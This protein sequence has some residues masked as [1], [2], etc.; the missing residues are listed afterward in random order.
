MEMDLHTCTCVYKY[1]PIVLSISYSQNC[2][3]INVHESFRWVGRIPIGV[4][5]QSTLFLK[6]PLVLAY[7]QSS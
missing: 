6:A 4:F 1:T 2:V 7:K 5:N 3:P